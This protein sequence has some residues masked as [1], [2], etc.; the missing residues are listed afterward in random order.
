MSAGA[1]A[2]RGLANLAAGTIVCC[3]LIASANASPLN[4]PPYPTPGTYDITGIFNDDGSLSGSF[5]ID[6][7]GYLVEPTHIVTTTGFI[8]RDNSTRFLRS[9]PLW[10]FSR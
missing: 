4:P 3:C 2:L 1:H 6:Q 8:L 7:Y 10:A 5:T 9:P